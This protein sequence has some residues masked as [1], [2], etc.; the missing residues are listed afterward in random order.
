M[1]ALLAE[2]VQDA[3]DGAAV[4]RV[5]MGQDEIQGWNDL[6]SYIT[7]N[8]EHPIRPLRLRPLEIDPES[9]DGSPFLGTQRIGIAFESVRHW[10]APFHLTFSG[11]AQMAP[12]DVPP[13]RL[14]RYHPR[15]RSG[16][17]KQAL[18][19]TGL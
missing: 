6:S 4:L 9:A 8:R 3:D 14:R 2:A 16:T 10:A 18:A 5:L 11:L 13:G 7:V 19:S 15:N 17:K 12:A 1:P